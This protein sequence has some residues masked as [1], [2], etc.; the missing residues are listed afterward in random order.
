[1]HT[2]HSERDEGAA[3]FH[4]EGEL[5]PSSRSAALAGLV[6][7]FISNSR[8]SAAAL[9]AL[10]EAIEFEEDSF[11]SLGSIAVRLVGQWSLPKVVVW[12]PGVAEEG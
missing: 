11:Q 1:M 9:L 10:E 2:K 12:R 7:P 4:A 8:P 5:A 3:A 6:I